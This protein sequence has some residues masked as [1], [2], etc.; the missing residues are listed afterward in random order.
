MMHYS[1]DHRVNALFMDADAL[2]E[3][4]EAMYAAEYEYADEEIDFLAGVYE[5][6]CEIRAQ[7]EIDRS[8]ECEDIYPDSFLEMEYEDRVSGFDIGE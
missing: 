5:Q 6:E 4:H 1:D 3:L 7:E 2:G 8:Y